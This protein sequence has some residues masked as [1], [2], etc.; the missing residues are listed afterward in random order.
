MLGLHLARSCV[1]IRAGLLCQE[2]PLSL[3]QTPVKTHVYIRKPIWEFC[4]VTWSKIYQHLTHWSR[5]CGGILSTEPRLCS[6]ETQFQDPVATLSLSK[7]EIP[8]R[9]WTSLTTKDY[10]EFRVTFDTL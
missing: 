2:R 1:L 9:G 3:G 10:W 6:R 7:L 8:K 4:I 5:K